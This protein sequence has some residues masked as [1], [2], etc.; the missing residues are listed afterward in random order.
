MTQ[1]Q[2]IGVLKRAATDQ[3]PTHQMVRRTTRKVG[4]VLSKKR[5]GKSNVQGITETGRGIANVERCISA[6]D[7]GKLI[8]G[9]HR[10]KRGNHPTTGN[11]E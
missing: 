9:N 11:N 4:A 3:N 7:D 8:V 6:H 5:R 10:T 1:E 2:A